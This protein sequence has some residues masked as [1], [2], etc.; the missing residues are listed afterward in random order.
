[1][2]A[3]IA[4]FLQQRELG[5]LL[6]FDQGLLQPAASARHLLAGVPRFAVF[7]GPRQQIQAF[8]Q[9]GRFGVSSTSGAGQTLA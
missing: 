8:A 3:R 2:A 4:G 5:L 1:M 9:A 7:P 6:V